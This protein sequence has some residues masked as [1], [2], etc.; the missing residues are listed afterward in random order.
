MAELVKC[1][2]ENLQNIRINQEIKRTTIQQLN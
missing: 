1:Y 2:Y